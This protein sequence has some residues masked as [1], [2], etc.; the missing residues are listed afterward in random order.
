L[1]YGEEDL[2]LDW[3]EVGI[4]LELEE[5]SSFHQHRDYLLKFAIRKRKTV[6]GGRESIPKNL[7]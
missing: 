5:S 4:E 3:S 6:L 2:D 7:L 1:E